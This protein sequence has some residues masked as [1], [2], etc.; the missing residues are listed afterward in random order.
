MG[1]QCY[2]YGWDKVEQC[3]TICHRTDT[4]KFGSLWLCPVHLAEEKKEQREDNRNRIKNLANETGPIRCEAIMHTGYQ[5]SRTDA[6]YVDGA[7]YRCLEH[8]GR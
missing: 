1:K 6:L 4:K 7:G 3:P 5:C 8:M 2:G